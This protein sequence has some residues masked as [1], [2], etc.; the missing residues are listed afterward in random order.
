MCEVSRDVSRKLQPTLCAIMALCRGNLTDGKTSILARS[1]C[2]EAGNTLHFAQENGSDLNVNERQK[3]R[4]YRVRSR[5][6][7]MPNRYFLLRAART[8]IEL[9]W[10][11]YTLIPLE[12]SCTTQ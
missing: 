5:I 9:L 3:I 6:R 7:K 11:C 2:R 8:R 1:S 12:I 10:R 4:N